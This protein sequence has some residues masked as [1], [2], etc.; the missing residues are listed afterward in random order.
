MKCLLFI[1]VRRRILCKLIL[2]FVAHLGPWVVAKVAFPF[3]SMPLNS[4]YGEC[5]GALSTMGYA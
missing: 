4:P 5:D 3:I 1:N 2:C